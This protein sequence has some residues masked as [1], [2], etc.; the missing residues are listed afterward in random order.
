ML[1]A[2]TRSSKIFTSVTSERAV[3]LPLYFAV[4]ALTEVPL[5][6]RDPLRTTRT[7]PFVSPFASRKAKALAVA[8]AG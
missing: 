4:E 5:E 2:V 8:D 3:A 6:V 7:S 1:R